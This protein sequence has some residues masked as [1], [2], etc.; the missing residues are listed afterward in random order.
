M[1]TQLGKLANTRSNKKHIYGRV[2]F[3]C[4][5]ALR[6]IPL[7][8]KESSRIKNG[9]RYTNC[10]MNNPTKNQIYPKASHNTSLSINFTMRQSQ[11]HQDSCRFNNATSEMNRINIPSLQLEIKNL[12][13]RQ[14]GVF[15]ALIQIIGNSEKNLDQTIFKLKLCKKTPGFKNISATT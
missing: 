4:Q 8:I 12:S 10:Q 9:I 13:M 6:K 11:S 3:P 15:K 5:K 2:T 14:I 1:K 7:A